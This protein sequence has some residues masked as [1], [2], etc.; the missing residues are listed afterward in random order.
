MPTTTLP[1]LPTPLVRTATTPSLAGAAARLVRAWLNGRSPNTVAAYGRDLR[2]FADFLGEPTLDAAAARLIRE[3]QGAANFCALEY[4]AALESRALSPATISRRLAALRS[5][6]RVAG[7]LGVVEW[8]LDAAGPRV[9]PFKDT[10][11]CGFA[12]YCAMLRA[13]AAQRDPTKARRDVALMRCLGDLG[14]RRAEVSA[15]DVADLDLKGE[16]VAVLGKGAGREKQWVT[17]PGP[18]ITAIRGWLAAR[19][20]RGL[21]ADGPLF[22]NLDRRDRKRRL[23]GSGLYRVVRYL[24]ERAGVQGARPHG[25]RHA[26]VTEVLALTNGNLRAA[27]RFARHRDPSTTMKYDDDVRDFAGEAARL[28]AAK[29]TLECPEVGII[30]P[31]P[32][33]AA[34]ADGDDSVSQVPPRPSCT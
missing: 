33:S 30:E 12:G 27:Q 31:L 7:L 17:L 22:L 28:L 11:G 10:R 20:G 32:G 3:G 21:P 26:A 8:R 18:T 34:G 19:A 13:A 5:L 4:R 9:L 25:V 6:V 24:G 14:L 29:A 16:R 15:L 23:M 1:P 2:D